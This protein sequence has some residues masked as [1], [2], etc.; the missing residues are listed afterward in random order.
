ML[1][2][3]RY[4]IFIL[5]D[6]SNGVNNM[7][8]M[9]SRDKGKSGSTKPSKKTKPLWTRHK[10]AE[11]ELIVVK[12]GKD[13]QT[14]SQ[15]G[16][17]LRDSYGIPDVKV[18]TKKSVSEILKEKK[19][20]PEI[21]DDLMALMK[22]LV[23]LEKHFEANRQDKTSLRGIQL[24]ESKI[25]RLVNYYKEIKKLPVDWKYDSKSIRLYTE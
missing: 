15:I 17:A 12:L 24:T 21:P 4:L 3:C 2:R 18:V 8:R 20:L 5:T 25:K 14:A 9:H 6:D 23:N 10:S 13:G 7:A 16:M 19:I 22:K 11:I 1:E